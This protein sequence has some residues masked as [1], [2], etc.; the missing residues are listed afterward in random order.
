MDVEAVGQPAPQLVWRRNG[1]PFVPTPDVNVVQVTPTHHRLE[2]AELFQSDTSEF[3][4]E[5]I[6]TLGRAVTKTNL[7][8]VPGKLTFH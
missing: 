4:V 8:V 5:A 1:T 7:V 2:V 6:N 3:T